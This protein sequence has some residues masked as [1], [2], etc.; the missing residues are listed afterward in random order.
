MLLTVSLETRSRAH[1]TGPGGTTGFGPEVEGR[2]GGALGV[3]WVAD[4]RQDKQLRSGSF[5]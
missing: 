2:K 3:P 4:W 5:E 1:H